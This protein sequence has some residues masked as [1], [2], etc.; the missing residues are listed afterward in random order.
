MTREKIKKCNKCVL[1]ETYPNI[2]FD[3]QG[4]CNYCKRYKRFISRKEEILINCFNEAKKS[5]GKYDVLVPLSGGKDS[6]FVLYLAKKKYNLKVLAYTFDNGFLSDTALRNID[7]AINK[8]DVDYIFYKPNWENMK[9]LYRAVLLYSGELCVVCGFGIQSSLLKISKD[10]NIPLVLVGTSQVEKECPPPENLYD[11]KRFEAILRDANVEVK[12]FLHKNPKV[13]VIEPLSYI[14]PKEDE[15]K[16][17]L[18]EEMDWEDCPKHSDCIAEPFSNFIREHR[19]GYSR[20]A[21]YFSVMIRMGEMKRDEAIKKLN[22]ENPSKEPRNIDSILKN[23]ELSRKDLNDI[24]KI[25]PFKYEKYCYKPKKISKLKPERI[26]RYIYK[27][28]K[29]LKKK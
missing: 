23:L 6:S 29:L 16:K 7:C 12:N 24:L 8:A 15:I 28:I 22:E 21:C 10:Y 4:V 11:Q 27:R 2:F 18:I 17:I 20:R 1:P 5:K 14:D 3:E 26:I 9:T 19:Y 25:E 13:K